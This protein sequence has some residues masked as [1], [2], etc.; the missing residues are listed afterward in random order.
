M[1][2]LTDE[3]DVYVD[4]ATG[5]IPPTGDLRMT[6]GVEA[7]MQGANIRLRQV[8]GEWFLN[9]ARGV[10]YFERDGVAARD[11]ILGQKFDR[12]KAIREFRRALLGDVSLGIEAVPGI[13][14]LLALDA[15]FDGKT[16]TLTVTWQA[17]TEFGDTP[18][19]VIA[20]GA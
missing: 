6:T 2:V 14:E 13:V 1:P 7:V 9:L 20:I 16:R 15:K 4:P 19:D 18:L 17:R 3:I 12:A 5:D 11:A 10:R 8:A